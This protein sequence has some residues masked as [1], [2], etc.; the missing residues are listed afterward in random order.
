MT[1]LRHS[2]AQEVFPTLQLAASSCCISHEVYGSYIE[3]PHACILRSHAES[4]CLFYELQTPVL[5]H[6]RRLLGSFLDGPHHA[7]LAIFSL[8][9]P[10]LAH[11]AGGDNSSSHLKDPQSVWTSPPSYSATPL[12]SLPNRPQRAPLT[13]RQDF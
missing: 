9:F 8:A 10:S 5:T 6:S 11:S 3:E 2:S 12:S 13:P 7:A 1:R 4:A